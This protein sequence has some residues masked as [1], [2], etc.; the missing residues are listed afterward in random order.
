MQ[1]AR[2]ALTL[3]GPEPLRSRPANQFPA[4]SIAQP[5]PESLPTTESNSESELLGHDRCYHLHCKKSLDS[6]VARARS[7]REKLKRRILRYLI[8]R[9]YDATDEEFTGDFSLHEQGTFTERDVARRI[10]AEKNALAAAA[11][12]GE[13][14]FGCV[15]EVKEAG[16][17]CLL[18]EESVRFGLAEYTGTNIDAKLR[19][20]SPSELV[21]VQSVGAKLEQVNEEIDKTLALARAASTS[22]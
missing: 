10:C 7:P 22:V 15:W 4:I 18:G 16:V 2:K 6:W 14:D 1:S 3:E 5:E 11:K 9:I 13:K 20:R 21:E 12:P 19:A 17:N 8:R